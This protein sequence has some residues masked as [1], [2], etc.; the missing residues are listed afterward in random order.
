LRNIRQRVKFKRLFSQ[1][2]KQ[3]NSNL[4]WILKRKVDRKM[5]LT[6]QIYLVYFS[7]L[8]ARARLENVGEDVNE[9]E[10]IAAIELNRE[11]NSCLFFFFTWN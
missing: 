11:S 4:S 7:L 6:F 8:H 5:N 3:K 1:V 9:E 10:K 2:S